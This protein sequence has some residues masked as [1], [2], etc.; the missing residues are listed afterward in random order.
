MTSLIGIKYDNL[1]KKKKLS[2]SYIVIHKF[3]MRNTDLH[4]VVYI[5]PHQFTVIS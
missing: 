1:I 3:F 2:E 4:L 5:E